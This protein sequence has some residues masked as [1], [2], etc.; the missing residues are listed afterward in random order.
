MEKSPTNCGQPYIHQHLSVPGE[1]F[2]G[3]E[4]KELKKL[5]EEKTSG[6]WKRGGISDFHLL[7]IL[8]AIHLKSWKTRFWY[9]TDSPRQPKI[10]QQLL[11]NLNLVLDILDIF[12]SLIRN[13]WFLSLIS[14]TWVAE[15]RGNEWEL[16]CSF[17]EGYAYNFQPEATNKILM[18]QKHPG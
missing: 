9:V 10:V 17:K 6:T 5:W 15:N 14:A 8:F 3:E 7:K 12:C 16:T 1:H 18:H 2:Y 13:K 4:L 11:A